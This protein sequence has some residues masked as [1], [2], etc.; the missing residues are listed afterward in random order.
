MNPRTRPPALPLTAPVLCH[1]LHGGAVA[2]RAFAQPASTIATPPAAEQVIAIHSSGDT[3]VEQRVGTAWRTARLGRGDLTLLPPFTPSEWRLHGPVAFLH[4]AVDH[5]W[6]QQFARSRRL[7][8]RRARLCM[9]PLL[10]QRDA[11]A[12][13]L[14]TLVWDHLH[15]PR[16]GSTEL[17]AATAEVLLAHVLERYAAGSDEP[18]PGDP[19]RLLVQEAMQFIEANLDADLR[20]RDLAARFRV[21]PY[22]L[23]RAFRRVAGVA[24]HRYL[25]SRRLERARALLRTTDLSVTRIAGLVGFQSSQHFATVFRRAFGRSPTHY[26]R[27]PG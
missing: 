2:L 17:L 21:T 25:V 20:G 23:I 6:L 5:D 8:A 11:T 1:A 22:A 24:P 7:I 26:R 16:A 3:V 19:G 27:D 13:A 10:G 15:R 18:E 4:V 14:G 9:R 12:A